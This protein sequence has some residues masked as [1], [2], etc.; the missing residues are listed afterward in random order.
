MAKAF[1]GPSLIRRLRPQSVASAP[2]IVLRNLRGWR[3]ITAII[4][5]VFADRVENKSSLAVATIAQRLGI[6]GINRHG[7]Q[8]VGHQFVEFF[9]E[10][11]MA[12]VTSH[13]PSGRFVAFASFAFMS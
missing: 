9:G 12:K 4:L 13:L 1:L 10:S 11:S 3:G 7:G 6:H 8:K 5:A 2:P